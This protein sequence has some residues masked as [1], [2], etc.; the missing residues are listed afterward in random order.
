MPAVCL[1]TN[2]LLY[3]AIGKKDEPQK[4]RIA[5]DLLDLADVVLPAQTLAEFYANATGP[6]Y[7][8]DQS[9]ANFWLDRLAMFPTVE[10]DPGLVLAGVALSQ[11]YRIHYFDGAIL[12]ACHR[13]AASVLYSEDLNHDQVYGDVRLINPFLEN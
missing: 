1:D 13:C 11:R 2:V 12:A 9:I 3:A 6:K 7:N 4:W 5:L 10:L 8:L